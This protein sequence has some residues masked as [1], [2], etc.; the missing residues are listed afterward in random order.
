MISPMPNIPMATTT[1]PIPSASWGSSKPKR[2]TPEL[3][4]VPT[5]PRSR[6][7]TIIPRAWSS[8][9]DASTMEATSPSTIREKY[10]AGPNL[11][12]NCARIG[13]KAATRKVQTVPAKN[14]PM[15]AVASATPACPWRAIW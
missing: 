8:E 5:R 10:S 14:D 11:R 7:S 3:T 2:W 1:K 4:S 15:A 6:P 13:P 12:A 9:P